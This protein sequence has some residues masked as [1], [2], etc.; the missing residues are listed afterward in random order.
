MLKSEFVEVVE[1]MQ[2]PHR[3][4][5]DN[6]CFDCGYVKPVATPKPTAK[7]TAA[8]TMPVVTDEPIVEKPALEDMKEQK[9]L[10]GLRPE[11]E[12]TMSEAIIVIAEAV[13]KNGEQQSVHVANVD[14][15][16]TVEE[17]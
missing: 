5:L 17:K 8:P 14:K 11:N 4:F 1:Y 7:P 12:T 9:Q 6:V 15:I 10:H 16:V 3:Y 13:E 2:R